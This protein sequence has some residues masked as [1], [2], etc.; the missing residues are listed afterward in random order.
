[1]E[2]LGCDRHEEGM[3]EVD[4]R[5]TGGLRTWHGRDAGRNE[6]F[7]NQTATF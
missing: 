3:E 4:F 7:K 5:G 1:M 2:G 6:V